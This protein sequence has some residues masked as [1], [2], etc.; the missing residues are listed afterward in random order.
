MDMNYS[1][2][3]GREAMNAALEMTMSERL[4]SAFYSTVCGMKKCNKCGHLFF[5]KSADKHKS[6]CMQY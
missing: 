3:M 5:Y 1:D 2:A 6:I 4:D